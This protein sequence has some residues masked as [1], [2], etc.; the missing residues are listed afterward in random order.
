[1]TEKD[2]IDLNGH[3]QIRAKDAM[4]G[5]IIYSEA[6]DDHNVITSKGASI[7]LDRVTKSAEAA[8][9]T[10]IYLGDDVGNGNLLNP[11]EE[12]ESYTNINQNIVY[13]IPVSDITLTYPDPFTF[14]LATVLNGTAIL[15]SMF[16]TDIDMR[17]TSATIRF[18][19]DE[20]FAYKRFPVRSLSRLVD[21]ELVWTVSFKEI[22][23]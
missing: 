13:Q 10:T 1:M 14:E 21:I 7:F 5:D 6:F 9:I 3:L 18:S 16:P 11:E 4:S 19:D 2:N 8:Y 23:Q 20:V 15:D 17:F 12:K 22:T